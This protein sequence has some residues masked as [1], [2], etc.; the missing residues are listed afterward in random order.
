VYSLQFDEKLC[1]ECETY[2]CL[3]RCQYINLS[4]DE[5]KVERWKIIRGEASRVLTECSTC[6]ACE[7]YCRYGNHPFYQIVELQEAKGIHPAPK[8]IE[9]LQVK[10]MAP[11]GPAAPGKHA[12]EVI[13]LCAFRAFE[14]MSIQGKLFEGTSTMGGNNLFCNLM[15][16]HF[17]RNSVIKERL[18]RSI[19]NI[20]QGH[21]KN[22]GLDE[23][24]CF[25]DECYATY[26]S[27]APAFGVN[28]PFKPIHFF[29]YVLDKLRQRKDKI[30]PLSMKVA[31]Q[32][33]CSNRLIPE[34]Q[35]LVDDIFALIGVERVAREYDR[36]NAL[37]CGGLFRAHGR[38]ELADDVQ[39]RNLRDMVEAGAVATVFNCQYCFMTLAEKVARR[40][41][42]PLLMSDLCRIAIGEQPGKPSAA[43]DLEIFG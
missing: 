27:W 18:P 2:D 21:L 13:N 31:Y 35:H 33:P 19:E 16:L 22:N 24:I 7:E 23:I 15:Y 10:M 41:M 8:P 3:T 1:T 32:R 25:H 40:G 39:Q 30:R 29:Q 37:C 43:P 34:T 38:D 26:T 11:K 6:Y 28:V 12:S 14:K 5:A 36:D 17:A 42:M 20:W 4:L 9:K